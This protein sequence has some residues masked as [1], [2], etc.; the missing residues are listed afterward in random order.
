LGAHYIDCNAADKPEDWLSQD[1]S[2]EDRGFAAGATQPIVATFWTCH[3]FP[4]IA[5]Y[6]SETADVLEF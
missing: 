2:L 4:S 6:T 5:C 1:L 3:K